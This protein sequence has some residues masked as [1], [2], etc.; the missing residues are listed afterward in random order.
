[1]IEPT[2]ITGLSFQD[3]WLEASRKVIDAGWETWN[4]V[5]H[6]KEPSRF[7]DV[8]NERIDRFAEEIGILIPKKVCYTI[9]PFHLY[10]RSRNRRLFYTGYIRKFFPRTQRLSNR[11]KIN[12]GTYFYRMVCYKTSREETTNQLENIIAAINT[13]TSTS[14]AAY[15]IIIAQPGT[16]TTRKMG[17]PCLN[18][19]AVQLEPGTQKKVGL[20]AV[21]RNH[22]FLERT[23]GNYWGLCQLLKFICSETNSLVGPITCISSHAYIPN[24]RVKFRN[25]IGSINDAISQTAI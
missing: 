6:I 15:T 25:F 22:D 24:N 19:I 2:I 7:S 13:R 8:F 10:E 5:A 16:E 12:W 17:G 14:R 21:Y 23:Y 1:M 18:Y 3:V 11:T 9:F 4:L 20:L